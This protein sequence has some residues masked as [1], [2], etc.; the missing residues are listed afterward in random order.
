MGE[1]VL[2]QVG[3]AVGAQLLPNGLSVLGQSFS[4]AFIG[5]TIGSLA[6]RAIDASMLSPIEG[7]RVKS[8]HVMESRDGAGLPLV[9]GRMRVGGQV[10]WASRFKEHRKEQSSGKGG[11]KYAN[12]TYSVSVAIALCQGPITRVDRIWANG[13]QITLSDYTWRLYR[14]D[15]TQL[16]DPLIEAIEGA[17]AAPAYRGTAY[18]V[19]EDLPLDAF[20]NRL[21]QFSFE[22]ARSGASNEARL[23]QT[24]EGVNIIPAS[25]EFVYATSIVRERRFPGTERPLNMNNSHGEADFTVS[26]RQLQSDLP[27]VEHAALT[28][29]WFGNDLRAGQCKIKPGVERRDRTCVPFEWQVGDAVRGSAHLISRTDDSPNYGGTPADEAVIEGIR[30]L[31][32]AGIDVT[33]SP[34]LLM[35]VPPGNGLPDPQGRHEQP[36]FP[37]RGRITVS[38]DKTAAAR[39]EIEAFVGEDGAFG[40]RHFI[41]HHARLAERAGG[42]AAILIGSEMKTL[43]K[44]R[45][46]RGAFPFVDALVEIAEEVR[47]IVGNQTNISYAA[48]WTEYGSHAPGDGSGD[49]LFPLDDLWASSAIDFVGVDWYPPASDWRSGEDH[50]DLLH[51]ALDPGDPDYIRSNLDGGE[52]FDWYYA[53]Q[54][55]RDAQKRTPIIDTAFGED[56]VFRQK[57]LLGWWRNAHHPR[58]NGHRSSAPSKWAPQSKPIRIIEIGFPAVDKGSNQPNVFYDPKSSESA[59]PNY[60]DGARDDVIQRQA[61]ATVLPYWKAQEGVEQ[62]LVWAWDGR[63]WPDFPARES[64]WSDGPNWQFG[65]WLN[66]RSGSIEVSDILT[67]LGDRT[68]II[69]NA[70][71]ARGEVDGFVLDDVTSLASAI[72]P[73][74][75]AYNFSVREHEDGLIAQSDARA[76]T[77]DLNEA[78]FLEPGASQTLPLLDK[79][80]SSVSLSYISGDFSYQPALSV[81]REAGADRPFS[82]QSSMPLVLSERI[83]QEIASD[84][85]QTLTDAKTTSVTLGPRDAMGLEIGDVIAY[86]DQNWR[87]ER[88]EI[89]G[90]RTQVHMRAD[91]GGRQS[92]RSVQTPD[93]GSVA[94]S[95]STPEFIIIDG[96]LRSSGAQTGL[97]V[98]VVSDP[99]TGSVPI[100]VG[101]TPTA[102][103]DRAFAISPAKIGRLGLDLSTGSYDQWDEVSEL[104]VELQGANLSSADAESVRAGQN[105]MLVRNETGWE[106]IGWQNADL[107]GADTWRLT[108]LLRGL[109]GSPIAPASKDAEIVLSDDALVE[110]SL[111]NDEYGRDL[112]W[113]IGT[114]EMSSFTFQD[115]GGLPWR[116]GDLKADI[117]SNRIE[118][119]WTPRG[120]GYSATG[121]LV[122]AA[123]RLMFQV[124]T[125]LNGVETRFPE[126]TETDIKLGLDSAD[127]ISVAQIG[128]DARRGEWVSILRPSS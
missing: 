115:L 61:L 91:A 87:L 27:R 20:G 104:F 108:G 16:P 76:V 13:E 19:F 56:W 114:A 106:L 48:D 98:A 70:E 35:D 77:F 66:G 119:S 17:G 2:S 25:G 36:A 90:L 23:A 30:A 93:P 121:R 110:I 84:Q 116:V 31:K 83:A 111:P 1:I 62:V 29:G 85:L 107:V 79:T 118:V 39:Q 8:L 14:G 75:A 120:R 128:P 96:P 112:Y 26:L 99:W 5:Q 101:A 44:I 7:P 41:L 55:D 57:D 72:A 113:Q 59:L 11:P 12:Y 46:D 6:G 100:R 80:P 50:L 68:R 94:I 127:E 123:Q 22:V 24:V 32:A 33:L 109:N 102:L 60:S 52:A 67:D 69:M 117:Q 122:D 28:V 95:V 43:T 92:K 82:V 124:R 71:G 38:Q 54:A 40:F 51:G 65:H 3:A 9:Y 125:R 126:Q 89:D 58:P 78:Q 63:P 73:L 18:I 88:I 49:V 10:I 64:V 105:R 21:P 81:V 74:S 97:V 53:S 42:V 45:D 37:W 86:D 103:T 34:F 15:K 4:G 47:A